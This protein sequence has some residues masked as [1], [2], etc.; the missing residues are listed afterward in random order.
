MERIMDP[1]RGPSQDQ[2]I[3]IQSQSRNHV[4]KRRPMAHPNQNK[5]RKR[6]NTNIT[7]V[8]TVHQT[9]VIAQ[10]HLLIPISVCHTE[11]L[12]TTQAH[13]NQVHRLTTILIKN[14]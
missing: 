13:Q 5:T 12:D 11:A 14:M 2:G 3:I 1:I 9:Q 6:K 10:A 4:R 8:I 7:P